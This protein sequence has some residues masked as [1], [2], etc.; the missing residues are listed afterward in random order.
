MLHTD[1]SNNHRGSD[2]VVSLFTVLFTTLLLT[3]LTVGFMRLMI[4]EQYQ[5]QN[6]DL[7]QSAYDSAMSGVEDAK[8]VIR[9]CRQGSVQAC[10]ALDNSATTCNTVYLA[11]IVGT[12]ADTETTI[13]SG[14][15]ADMTLNQAYTCVKITTESEDYLGNLYESKSKIIPLRATGSFN[16]IVIQWMHKSDGSIGGEGFAGGNVNDLT[17]PMSPDTNLTSLPKKE[18]WSATAPAMLR[19][20][21]VLPPNASSVS[22]ADLDGPIASTTFLRPTVTALSEDMDASTLNTNVDVGLARSAVDAGGMAHPVSV[23]CSKRLF[24]ED[25]D[26]ACKAT[27]MMPAGQSVPAESA[28]AFLRLTSLYRD[29]AYRIT[30]FNDSN[31]VMFDGV[32]PTVDS[33]GRASNIY[34]RVASKL[35]VGSYEPLINVDA[36]V[37]TTG[38]LCK[39]FYITDEIADGA[40]C[41]SAVPTP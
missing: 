36:T 27:L 25:N 24:L 26:Y 40:V 15:T 34:R 18:A 9:A 35:D 1:H 6:Q 30:L 4:Q 33:T 39:D 37:T 38:S 7:A 13:S 32:Q 8:R 20:M 29:T 23:T 28:V 19:A 22:A 5:A 2:G 16:R 10:N 14:N 11:G 41:T 17:A 12:G 31:P 21:T 3:V